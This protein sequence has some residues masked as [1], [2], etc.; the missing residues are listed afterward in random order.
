MTPTLLVILQVLIF[1]IFSNYQILSAPGS[2]LRSFFII[3]STLW[4]SKNSMATKTIYIYL[5]KFAFAARIL[6]SNLR[7]HIIEQYQ[8]L[9]LDVQQVP[10]PQ[11]A[12]K[13]LPISATTTLSHSLCNNPA[14]TT[15]DFHFLG[16]DTSLFLLLKPKDIVSSLTPL[17]LPWLNSSANLTDSTFKVH[18][19][20]NHFSLHITYYFSGPN[21][22]Y[23]ER[24]PAGLSSSTHAL[25]PLHFHSFFKIRVRSQH[26]SDQKS[27]LSPI[28]LSIKAKDFVRFDIV[29][30]LYL[31]FQ[32]P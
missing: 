1:L 26:S 22:Q 17:F 6:P 29:F 9:C 3:N 24:L 19:K 30:P 5:H 23:L 14:A 11:Y 21:D 31:W 32:L 16:N 7:H 20:V 27:Q 4:W 13:W 18:W 25:H 2:V 12:Q 15:K 8:H 10:G 28:S